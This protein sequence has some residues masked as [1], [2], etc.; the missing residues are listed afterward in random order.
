M[1]SYNVRGKIIDTCRL[2]VF[3]GNLVNRTIASNCAGVVYATHGIYVWL[4][5]EQTRKRNKEKH[6]MAKNENDLRVL[7]TR[8]AILNSFRELAIGR[9]LK[10]ISIKEIT[11]RAGINRKTFYLHYHSIEDLLVGLQQQFSEEIIAVMGSVMKTKDGKEAF[12]KTLL[13]LAGDPEWNYLVC[14]RYDYGQIWDIVNSRPW[15][16]DDF[17]PNKYYKEF[18]I[19]Y[20]I[21]SIRILFCQ[22]YQDGM[23]IPSEIMAELGT[24]IAFSGITDLDAYI[25]K[26]GM[27]A[28]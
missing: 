11:D 18:L 15:N 7:R 20:L 4:K 5:S 1:I 28:G 9:D 3:Y 23:V 13:Y 8:K 19:T 27:A 10:D 14:S 6:I 24:Q 22:W 25:D 21:N 12:R 2:F 17:I 16:Y 26:N